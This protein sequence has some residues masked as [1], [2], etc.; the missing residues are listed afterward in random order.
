MNK[1]VLHNRFLYTASII[2]LVF[3]AATLFAYKIT[4]DVAQQES[5]NRFYQDSLKIQ[6]WV[7]V[8]LNLYILGAEGL[9]GLMEG[10]DDV[11][12]DEWSTYIKKV[13]L[14]KDYPGISSINYVEKVENNNKKAF[15]ESVRKD[16]SLNP[17]GY[18]DFN[19]YPETDKAEYFVVKYIEPFE[20]REKAL[21]FD[22]GSEDK[23]L[24]ALERARNSGKASSTGKI[25][26]ATTN[27][28]GFG[29]LIPVYNSKINANS[30][31]EERMVNIKGF[32]YAIF[33]GDEVFKAVYGKTDFF[34]NV[35]FEIYDSENLSEDNLLYDRNPIH[36][37]L[38]SM[39]KPG[40]HTKETLV[41]D[42]QNWIILISATKGFSLTKSQEFLP[43][44]VLV[45]GLI[46]SFLFL[47]LF[48]RSFK[49]HLAIH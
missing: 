34:P 19:I 24:Q 23:R 37:I 2:F 22:L 5:R 14:I 7:Q 12:R 46:F 26:L 13:K 3:L 28:P 1:S 32:V 31:T 16:T 44:T 43:I 4:S 49:Q 27:A 20:D 33:R 47:G 38:E 15:V 25:I 10:S 35:D 45:S 30:T 39:G 18:P 48:L 11:R 29:L 36:K 42:S 40:L 41:I 8:K 17:K 21:G 9:S 6:N